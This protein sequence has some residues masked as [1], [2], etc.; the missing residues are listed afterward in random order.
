MRSRRGAPCVRLDVAQWL[1]L[2]DLVV[3][4]GWLGLIMSELFRREVLSR[5]TPPLTGVVVL[6]S[7]RTSWWVAALLIAALTMAVV[8]AAT[9]SYARKETVTGWLLPPAG[10]IRQ[11]ARQGGIIEALHVQE[12]QIIRQGQPI[13]TVRLSTSTASGDS[14]ARLTETFGTQSQASRMQAEAALAG[15]EEEE[16]ALRA[17]LGGLRRERGE[18]SRRVQLQRERLSLAQAELRR[19]E[20][21]AARGFLPARELEARRTVV[22]QADQ[23]LSEMSASVLTINRQIGEAQSRLRAIP[24][25]KRSA[26]A[27]ADSIQAGIKQQQTQAESAATYI[28]VATV[29]GRV[30]AIPV[31][32]GQSLETGAAVAIVGKGDQP[33]EAELYVPSRAA[34]FVRPGQNVRLMYQAFPFQK[35]GAGEGRI[36]SVSRTV[37]APTE[38]QLPGNQLKEPVFRVRAKIDTGAVSAYGQS[39]PLQPGMLLNADIVLDR[40]NLFEWL[41][42]PLYAA[43]RR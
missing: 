21:V 40:R 12:G 38:I 5:P 26:R 22:L 4:M 24:I 10:L 27:E 7:S 35:F 16:S 37:L 42:D 14:F 29:A 33:L 11:A 28:V 8:F 34:G 43:G 13:A 6:R 36:I 39:I 30:S 19:A 2:V 23:T 15:L 31:S 41:L 9:A 3:G 20:P 1:C 32:I 17:Q 18:A 25:E